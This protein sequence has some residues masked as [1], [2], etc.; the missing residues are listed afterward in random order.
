MAEPFADL[1]MPCLLYPDTAD[2]LARDR[3]RAAAA[4]PDARAVLFGWIGHADAFDNAE[5][6]PYVRA[7]LARAGERGH[8]DRG[9]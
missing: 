2:H 9:A 4:M 7:F 5:I 3:P 8:A 6:V 1:A